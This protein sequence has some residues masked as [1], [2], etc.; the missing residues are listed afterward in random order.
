MSK[1]DLVRAVR[2]L[3]W[4]VD[5]LPSKLYGT[6]KQIHEWLRGAIPVPASVATLVR[7]ALRDRDHQRRTGPVSTWTKLSS[8]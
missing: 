5:E 2:A 4:D 7:R 3:G 6:P 8:G 1:D